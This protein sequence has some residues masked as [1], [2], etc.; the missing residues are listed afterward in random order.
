MRAAERHLIAS[1]QRALRA[2]FNESARAFEWLRSHSNRSANRNTVN[3]SRWSKT[4]LAIRRQN[5]ISPG[6]NDGLE[7]RLS[8][9]S[10]L[11]LRDLL[12]KIQIQSSTRFDSRDSRTSRHD[13]RRR[14]YLLEEF[15]EIFPRRRIEVVGRRIILGP[16]RNCIFLAM[17][18]PKPNCHPGIF[19]QTLRLKLGSK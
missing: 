13:R 16:R 6:I 8:R 5:I 12:L 17:R 19:A 3:K 15:L 10:P 9:Q 2:S 11:S 7:R 14:E 1:G 4:I 18:H